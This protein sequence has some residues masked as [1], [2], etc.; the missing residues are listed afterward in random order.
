PHAPPASPLGS[1][2]YLALHGGICSGAN[3][4]GARVGPLH[5]PA[6]SFLYPSLRPGPWGDVP[7]LRG[8]GPVVSWL[9]RPGPP[10]KPAVGHVSPEFVAPLQFGLCPGGYG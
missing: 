9:P 8:L 7:L 5:P 3:V 6:T 2:G 1:R 4:L 10:E